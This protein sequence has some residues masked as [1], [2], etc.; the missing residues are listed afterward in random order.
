MYSTPHRGRIPSASRGSWLQHSQATQSLCSS[1][2]VNTGLIHPGLP[3]QGRHEIWLPTDH[4]DSLPGGRTGECCFRLCLVRSIRMERGV[5][6]QA[7]ESET[8]ESLRARAL[9]TRYSNLHIGGFER[10][11]MMSVASTRWRWVRDCRAAI[12]DDRK[13]APSWP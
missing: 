9:T 12:V 4:R 8:T 7:V 13:R 11:S 2:R 10:A 3:P 6:V 1:R 5:F